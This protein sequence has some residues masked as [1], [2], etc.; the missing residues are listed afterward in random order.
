MSIEELNKRCNLDLFDFKTTRELPISDEIIGQKRATKALNFGLSINRKGYNVFVTGITGTGRNSYS[1]SLAKKFAKGKYVPSDWC[2]VYNFDKPVRPKAIELKAGNGSTFKK[3]VEDFVCRLK[4]EIP[5]YFTSK[6]YEDKKSNIY[7][8]FDVS[9][10]DIVNRLNDKAEKYGFQFKQTDR[11]LI[12]YPLIE[13]RPM[14]E[15]ELQNLSEED[16]LELKKKSNEM[17][18]EVHDIL[19]EFK[20]MENKLLDDLDEFNKKETSELIKDYMEELV[21]EFKDNED[22]TN[23]L[24]EL[25]KDIV[26]NL[27]KFLGK[28]DENKNKKITSKLK[29]QEDFFKRYEINL[30]IDN[31][32]K[33]NAPVIREM[34]P[35]YYNLLGK[36]EYV[37]EM[38]VLRTDHTMIKPGS[39]HEANGGFLI[40]QAKDILSSSFAWIGLKRALKSNEIQIENITKGTVIAETIKPEPIPIE[41]KVIIVGD[42]YTYQMLYNYDA[43]FKKLFKIRADFDIEIERNEENIKK[44]ALFVANHCKDEELCDFSKDAIGRIVE[45]SSRLSGDKRK[46]STRFNEIVELLYEADAMAVASEDHIV[47]EKHINM[48]IEEKIYRNNKYEEKLH[49]LFRD[50]TLMIETTG[51]KVGQING[52]AVLDSGQYSFGRPSKITVSTYAGKDGITNIEREVEQSGNI[53][54]KGVLILSGY[55]GA[56]Y[57]QNTPLSLNASITFE[58]SYDMVDGDSASSTELYAILSSISELPIN[59]SIAVT[60]SVNQKGEIQPIGGVN[61]KIEGF[62]KVCKEKGLKGDEGVIIPIQNVNNLMLKDE[63][64]D[65]VKEGKFSIYAIES[66][67]EGI[68][69]LTGVEYG[70][71]D[72][73][74]NY[75]KDTVNYLVQKKL[76]YY[77]DLS[78]EY[79]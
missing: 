36:I 40:I 77:A 35:N 56:K 21:K 64:I 10:Q 75:S 74:G 37:N 29:L 25:E 59:Q 28:E 1:Y 5:K 55:L 22:V 69:I 11:G 2:Y 58:Q 73:E 44:I 14:K 8:E 18:S 16:M 62:F 20:D 61:E 70:K 41:L 23:H 43:D 65:A 57:A 9:N 48:A 47:T 38:G 39:I 71:M 53:H 30:F 67:D 72:K 50:N 79:E 45:Y 15:E 76:D 27:D 6:E 60:G 32:N 46:L 78:K 13:G 68:E 3:H 17:S 26:K 34:N 49:E 52:L 66:I 19:I 51:Y 31:S 12:T 42:Y 24:N 63:V 33:K 54:D 4:T 7:N